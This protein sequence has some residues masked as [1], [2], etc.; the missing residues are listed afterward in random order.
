[1]LGNGKG[2]EKGGG[3]EGLY[4]CRCKILSTSR[5]HGLCV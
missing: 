1:M 5:N 4:R 2:S 3:N